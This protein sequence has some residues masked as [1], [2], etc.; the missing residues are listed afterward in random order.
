MTNFPF[1]AAGY[2]FRDIDTTLRIYAGGFF[3]PE[4]LPLRV[5]EDGLS[6]EVEGFVLV[7]YVNETGLDERDVGF[8]NVSSYVYLIRIN[9]SGTR[10]ILKM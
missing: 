4:L 1:S 10:S 6:E 7:V 3:V 2:D 5:Y 8:V 9:Q